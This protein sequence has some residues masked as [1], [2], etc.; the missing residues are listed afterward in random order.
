MREGEPGDL[1]ALY[2]L[3]V[4]CF[5]PPFR[6]TRAAIGEFSQAPGAFTIV[7]E[8]DAAELLGFIILQMSVT[9]HEI[10]AYVVTLDVTPAC[11]RMGVATT[12]LDSCEKVVERQGRARMALHVS[13]ENRGAIQFYE[14]RG[15][16]RLQLH[17]DFYAQG[18][19]AYGYVKRLGS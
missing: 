19:S 17:P 4:V 18:L 9:D 13:A 10:E 2:R 16:S 7:A 8:D 11:R 15:Y 6:F 1:D 12:L 3:D 14:E 5:E